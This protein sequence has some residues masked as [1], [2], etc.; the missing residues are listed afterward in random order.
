MK[1]SVAIPT[2]CKL[3]A[4]RNLDA[5]LPRIVLLACSVK[6]IFMVKELVLILAKS[7]PVLMERNAKLLVESQYVPAKMDLPRISSLVSVKSLAAAGIT[8]TVV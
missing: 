3:D 4:A 1:V 5:H 8:M 6:S 7:C 2:I